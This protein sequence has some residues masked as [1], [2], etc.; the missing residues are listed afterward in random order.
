M[1]RGIASLLAVL[2]LVLLLTPLS[3]RAASEIYYDGAYHTYNGN[4]FTLKVNGKTVDCSVPPIVFNDYSV[5]PARDVFETLGATVSWRAEDERVTVNYKNTQIILN[6]NSTVAYKNGVAEKMPIAP[7][8]INAKTMIPARYVA[9][10][11]GFDV[12]FDSKTDTISIAEK[13]PEPTY[14]NTLKS[15]RITE[16]D[17]TFTLSMT[18]EKSGA[19]ASA[20]MMTAP[21]RLVVDIL[22]TRHGIGIINATPESE[23]VTGVRFGLH[24]DKLRVVLDLSGAHKYK[25]TQSG[26]TITVSIGKNA[27]TTPAPEETEKPDTSAK[28]DASAKPDE[29]EETPEVILPVTEIAPSRSITIDAGHGGSDPG[30]VYTDEDGTLWRET[31]INLAIALKVR[32]ILEKQGV[33]V[34]MTRTTEKDVA[35]KARPELANK[36]ET[37]LF[38]SVHTN[39]VAENNTANGIETWG[40]LEK[41]RP[42]ADVTDKSFAQN[43]QKAVIKATKANDRGIKDS[44]ELAVIKHSI[45]PS[46]L[47]EVGF[48]TNETERANLFNDA[49][50]T[51]IAQGI[52][53]GVLKTFEDMG[54]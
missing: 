5:V 24:A 17:E 19:K 38:L 50:R 44:I 43:V 47:V 2:F 14:S 32:D 13:E 25:L 41:G 31:D 39:S 6:I 4:F 51:K 22:D 1:K 11:L 36:E 15:Y 40:N 16:K 20:F 33:R 9:E 34:V 29:P 23:I 49:Y 12:N 8:I 21:V 27:E 35:L 42:L 54:V 45:M 48:I 37:A 10:S 46:V 7:K 52:A 3:A 26:K 18:L 30:A 53:E 28:P